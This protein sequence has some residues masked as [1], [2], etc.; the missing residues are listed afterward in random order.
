MRI[1]ITF[2]IDYNGAILEMHTAAHS[3][4]LTRL[5]SILTILEVKSF[6]SYVFQNGDQMIV[7]TKLSKLSTHKAQK[8]LKELSAN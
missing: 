3:D 6:G 5:H 2:P 4:V 7:S 1:S 8:I